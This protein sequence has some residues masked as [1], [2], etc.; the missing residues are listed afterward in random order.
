MKIAWLTITA[1]ACILPIALVI[2]VYGFA[3]QNKKTR[4]VQRDTLLEIL[5]H[6]NFSRITASDP[7]VKH[8]MIWK[9]GHDRL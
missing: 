7:L 2:I 4:I 8:I 1:L 5:K 3:W 9:I 6:H